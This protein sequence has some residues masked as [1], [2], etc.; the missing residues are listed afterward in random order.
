MHISTKSEQII[1]V[2][3][4]IAVLPGHPINCL[5]V[6]PLFGLG[7][8]WGFGHLLRIPDES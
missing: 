3:T 2:H 1:I 8:S 5:L 6:I 7:G 4:Y